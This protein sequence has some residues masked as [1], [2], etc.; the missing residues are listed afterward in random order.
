[1]Q[2]VEFLL[3]DEFQSGGDI[4]WQ[5]DVAAGRLAEAAGDVVA[6]VVG[7][8]NNELKFL[9]VELFDDANIELTNGM[10]A[11]VLREEADADAVAIF[12][13]CGCGPTRGRESCELLHQV[14]IIEA[15]IGEEEVAGCRCERGIHRHM[16]RDEARDFIRKTLADFDDMLLVAEDGR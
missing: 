6:A 11:E 3:A 14:A 10:V 12:S 15:L 16:V 1:V 8:E 5:L 2:D 4:V 13:W 9:L 7:R